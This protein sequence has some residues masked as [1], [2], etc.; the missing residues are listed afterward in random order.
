MSNRITPEEITSVSRALKASRCEATGFVLNHDG[1][2]GPCMRA[3]A[4]KA[5]AEYMRD[6]ENP[7]FKP[8]RDTLG[9][10]KLEV[11]TPAG[12]M[13]ESPSL[14]ELLLAFL[15]APLATDLAGGD[16]STHCP[17]CG[18]SI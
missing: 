9:G 2:I 7:S 14:T 13:S 16:G 12:S 4:R 18:A 15:S 1:T 3:A 8:L 17:K 11:P 6:P 5:Q 10:L